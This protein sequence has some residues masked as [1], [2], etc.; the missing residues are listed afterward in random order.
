MGDPLP[1]FARLPAEFN[2]RAYEV[3]GATFAISHRAGEADDAPPIYIVGVRQDTRP[4]AASGRPRL[5]PHALVQE[6]LNRTE[7]LW[8]LI[9]NGTTLRLLRD[10]TFVRRQAYIEFDLS[11]IFDEQRFQDFSALYRLL[12]R[13][14]LPRGLGGRDQLV[15]RAVLSA[16]G[17]AGWAR[18]GAL[19]RG[20]GGLHSATGQRL[21][22]SSGKASSR[23]LR[24]MDKA[25]LSE[26]DLY[27]QLLRLV[28]RLL[29]L[30]VS[31]DRG[32]LGENPI[33]REHYGIARLRRLLEQRAAYTD[34]DDLWQSLR[35]LWKVFSNERLASSLDL[36]P[37]NGELFAPQF[38]D[39][40]SIT[41]RDLL[42][43]F[44]RLA[45]YQGSPSSL[46][47]RVNYAALDV[48]ELGSVYESLLEF[49]PTIDPQ[50]PGRLSSG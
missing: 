28:Y 20:C 6:Y 11:A 46:P 29:F 12:H 33:Y 22:A 48:E 49:H 16:L 42:E 15:H 39:D 50:G 44:W 17:R 30:I 5:S 7:H 31:E 14:R 24:R 1:R 43:A 25:R 9:A 34:H 47:R 3:D 23:N 32:L 8:G 35:V 4:R 26:H 18:A 37:L 21:S 19:A 13:S 2:P 36:A 40:C 41:N 45:W 38:L 10:S 27:R